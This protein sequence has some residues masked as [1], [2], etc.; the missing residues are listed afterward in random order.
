MQC[1][2]VNNGKLKKEVTEET[3]ITDYV[4]EPLSIEELEVLAFLKVGDMCSIEGGKTIVTRT[5]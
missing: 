1:Y 4:L 3:L 2:T 5:K